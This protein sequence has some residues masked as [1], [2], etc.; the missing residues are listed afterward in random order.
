[1]CDAL[2]GCSIVLQPR[3]LIDKILTDS[4][5]E[6]GQIREKLGEEDTRIVVVVEWRNFYGWVAKKIGGCNRPS[7]DPG[8]LTVL[9]SILCDE[10]WEAFFLNTLI[11]P[12][13]PVLSHEP[14]SVDWNRAER[15][16][17]FFV[18]VVESLQGYLVKVLRLTPASS[19]HPRPIFVSWSHL[20]WA[21]V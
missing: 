18:R 9:I 17:V 21:G 16:Q 8:F 4:K 11:A 19:Y 20:S 10:G 5:M 13:L 1:M 7:L 12:Y 14:S 3:N 15:N 2:W 6:V